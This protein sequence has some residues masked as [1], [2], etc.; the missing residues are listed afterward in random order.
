MPYI[1]SL[2]V[3]FPLNILDEVAVTRYCSNYLGYNVFDVDF[4]DNYVFKHWSAERNVLLFDGRGRN[5]LLHGFV[6]HRGSQPCPGT[7][8][9]SCTAEVFLKGWRWKLIHP[10]LQQRG[11]AS[12]QL[13]CHN[14]GAYQ[15]CSWYNSLIWACRTCLSYS[16]ER[17]MPVISLLSISLASTYC[18]ALLF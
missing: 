6:Q 12:L 3:F 2:N 13:L 14:A 1:H 9:N 18:Y 11:R 10:G 7:Q 8:L 15:L 17:M 5:R 4:G 16:L